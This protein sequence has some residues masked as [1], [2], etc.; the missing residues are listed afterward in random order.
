MSTSAKPLTPATAGAVRAPR[1]D[2]RLL[3]IGAGVALAAIS[4]LALLNGLHAGPVH[5]IG[6]LLAL[7]AALGTITVAELTWQRALNTATAAGLVH[8]DEP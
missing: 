4:A 8:R 7:V 5:W 3:A 1:M 6:S 2:R